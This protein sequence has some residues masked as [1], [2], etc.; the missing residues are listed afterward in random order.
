MSFAYTSGLPARSGPADCARSGPDAMD[1]IDA[2][3]IC[4]NWLQNYCRMDDASISTISAPWWIKMA[5]LGRISLKM[6]CTQPTPPTWS[7]PHLQRKQ[8]GRH[9]TGELTLNNTFENTAFPT[10]SLSPSP[11]RGEL[12]RLRCKAAPRLIA[13]LL[14]SSALANPALRRDNGATSGQVPPVKRTLA[15]CAR[16]LRQARSAAWQAAAPAVTAD[17]ARPRP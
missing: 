16:R 15:I 3:R 5:S 2:A 1:G 14:E 6:A 12:E 9:L 11:R 17:E 4:D 13:F 10:P 7:W 8:F